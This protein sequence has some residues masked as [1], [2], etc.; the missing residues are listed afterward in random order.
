MKEQLKKLREM[1]GL[2]RSKFA[3]KV[4][5]SPQYISQMELGKQGCTLKTLK[6]F[7]KKIGVDVQVV[8]SHVKP[9]CCNN[10]KF[11]SNNFCNNSNITIYNSEIIDKNCE[12]WNI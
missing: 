6:R 7:S 3:K 10:C 5:V 12:L 11:Y 8:F 4:G 1:S 9:C 2:N